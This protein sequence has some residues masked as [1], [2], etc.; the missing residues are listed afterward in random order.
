MPRFIYQGTWTD[1]NGVVVSG[2]TVTVYLAG[3]TTKA[4][5]YAAATGDADA[6][7][8]ITSGTDG[9]FYFY[10]DTDDYGLGQKFKIILSKTSFTSKTYDNVEIF[11]KMIDASYWTS[12]AAAVAAIDSTETFA[13]RIGR[14]DPSLN[15]VFTVY[16]SRGIERCF[17]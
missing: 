12:F 2:G 9:H 17:R 15:P 1:G 3:T 5:I 13:N 6:D 7:S 10:V 8:A 16:R 14:R 11:P 4:T